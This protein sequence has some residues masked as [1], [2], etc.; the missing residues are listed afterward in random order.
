ME[1][2][3]TAILLI[4]EEFAPILGTEE[5]MAMKPI[6]REFIECYAEN[7]SRPV[8]EWLGQKIQEQLP[9]RTPE[10]I[11]VMTKEIIT[12][13]EINESNK[14]SLEKAVANGRSKESWFAS[15]TKKAVSKMSVKETVEYLGS[16][17]K[18]LGEAKRQIPES[19]GMSKNIL[20]LFHTAE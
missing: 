6:I 9:D 2:E 10:E 4:D 12:T 3:A 15:Q 11:Q 19:N 17:D 13:I 7:R 16:L 1:K 20:N 14:A 8:E 5:C 18:A